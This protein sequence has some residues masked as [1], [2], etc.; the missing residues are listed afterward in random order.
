MS[1]KN[2]PLKPSSKGSAEK[3]NF[4]K[5]KAVKSQEKKPVGIQYHRILV[6]CTNGKSFYTY[7]TI[8]RKDKE[9]EISAYSDPFSH[10]AWNK[11]RKKTLAK[12]SAFAAKFGNFS[13]SRKTSKDS[14][15]EA[16]SE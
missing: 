15:T 10:E 11:G 4:E 13:L 7:S 5:A 14:L 12:G 8:G 1:K 2:Q 6:K 3:P 9:V 16:V